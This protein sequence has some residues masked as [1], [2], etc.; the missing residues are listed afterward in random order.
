MPGFGKRDPGAGTFAG[1]TLLDRDESGVFQHAEMLGQVA[2]GQFECVA[3][4]AELDSPCLV[5][6]GK[7]AE[8]HPLMNDV[9]EPVRGMTGHG[10]GVRRGRWARAKPM[11]LTSSTPPRI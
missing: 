11:P 3:Q 7:N 8:P 4:V 9:V 5:R 10:A 1:V 6:D 2:G